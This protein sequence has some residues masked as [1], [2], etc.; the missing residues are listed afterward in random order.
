MADQTAAELKMQKQLAGHAVPLKGRAVI[1][2]ETR[3]IDSV[4]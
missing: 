1:P 3:L 2:G 4:D